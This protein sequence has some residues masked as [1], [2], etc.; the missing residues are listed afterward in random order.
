LGRRVV[1]SVWILGLT[2]GSLVLYIWPCIRVCEG[3]CECECECARGAGVGTVRVWVRC[4]CG[5]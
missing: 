4:E 3:E 5:V 2:F 1:N